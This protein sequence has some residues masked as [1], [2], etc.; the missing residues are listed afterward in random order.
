MQKNWMSKNI[1]LIIVVKKWNQMKHHF[2]T[3]FGK[4]GINKSYNGIYVH[5]SCL[6]RVPGELTNTYRKSVSNLICHFGLTDC[7]K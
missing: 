3:L 5:S 7:Q 4:S 6:C 1:Q 2:Y